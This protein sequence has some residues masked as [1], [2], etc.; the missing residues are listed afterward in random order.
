MIDLQSETGIRS[1]SSA[2]VCCRQWKR[3]CPAKVS[4]FCRYLCCQL[5]ED[6]VSVLVIP[7][8][9]FLGRFIHGLTQKVCRPLGL[10]SQIGHHRLD[11]RVTSSTRKQVPL[12]SVTMIAGTPLVFTISRLSATCPWTHSFL[13]L[14]RGCLLFLPDREA[15]FSS[16]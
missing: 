4:W 7:L 14:F 11:P 16:L 8:Q 10:R 2:P 1:N 9:H 6:G 15:L 5:W 12:G 13:A 3:M